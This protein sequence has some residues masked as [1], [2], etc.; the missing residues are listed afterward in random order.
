MYK[1]LKYIFRAL[2]FPVDDCLTVKKI[3][4]LKRDAL[5]NNT[6]LKKITCTRWEYILLGYEVDEF[7]DCY[8]DENVPFFG[9]IMGVE[10]TKDPEFYIGESVIPRKSCVLE[11]DILVEKG[12]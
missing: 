11:G 2:G 6:E 1:R 9:Y 4:K 7:H 8:I 5:I 3:I 12:K 10:L